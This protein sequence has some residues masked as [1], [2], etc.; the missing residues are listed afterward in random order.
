MSASAAVLLLALVCGHALSQPLPAG[1]VAAAI[2][3][4]LE[5][6]RHPAVG[7]LA[8]T[9]VKQ[10]SALYAGDGCAPLWVDA[11]GR[12][13]PD[14]RSALALLEGAASEGLDPADYGGVILRRW[15]ETLE[16]ARSRAAADAAAFDVG[17]SAA[18][19]RYLRQLHEGRVD[20]RAIGFHMSS[21]ADDNHDFA[22]ILR[23]ALASHRIPE[24]AAA[25]TPPLVLYR[26]LR[27]ALARYR[28]L[29]DDWTLVAP[30]APAKPV[31]PGDPYP[32][33]AD[34]RR[35]LS[36][37]GDLPPEAPAP[38]PPAADR[39]ASYE[40]AL[41][42]GVKRFQ[43]RH[44]L[45]P[46]GVLGKETFA[47]LHVPLAWR[48]RQ[49]ELAL[50]RLRWLP[51]LSP[52][53]FLAVNIPMYRLWAWT[54]IPPSGAPALGMKV[55]VGRAFDR[56]TPVFVDEMQ[57]VIFR[58]Y[59]NVPPSIARGE[60]LPAIAR[61]PGYLQRQDM[62]IVAG[63]GDDSRP[64]PA[65][66]ANLA[67]VRQGKLR[68][69]QRPGPKNALGLVKFVFPNDE[70]VYLHDTPAPQL[71]GRTRRDFSHGCVRVEDPAALAE[72]AL[73]GEGDWTRERIEA[74]MNGA[75]SQRVTLRRPIQVILFYV[76]AVV[77]PEDGTVHFADDV[78]GHDR[79]LHAALAGRGSP[80]R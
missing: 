46:D 9:E 42:D 3:R 41:V 30:P 14:S 22:S 75:R 38:S 37:L 18:T 1:D 13:G 20:P 50:E 25:F 71:F 65:T 40:G 16:A 79:R 52:E 34:L 49:I 24:T 51:H 35:L 4:E 27:G 56:E 60:V 19:L 47:A 44:G 55:I 21:P 53:R 6:H 2:C 66:A 43:A 12:P 36:A 7:S 5:N 61:R 72:W 58:P 11:S 80:A 33:V 63:P 68:V 31:R 48:A 76:T 73:E 39:P 77:M 62:E 26:G 32:G 57:Y 64:V 45:E 10:L 23:A 69:R 78:Y 17:M 15:A 59:W 74:A 54:G 67:L 8:P 29:A 70:N 28:A